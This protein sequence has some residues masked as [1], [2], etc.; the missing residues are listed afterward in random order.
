MAKYKRRIYCKFCDFFC[1]EPD[2]F[3]SHLEKHHD[4][5]IPEDMTPWQFSYYL[6]TNKT[7]GSCIVCKKDTSWN[8]K[9]HKYNRFCGNPACKEKYKELFKKRMIG[10]YG[11][12]TLLN[13]PEHQ[14]KMLANRKISG[15]Y[16]WR[17]HVHKTNYTGSY[18]KDFLIFLDQIMNFDPEDVMAPSPHTYYY[19]YEG[20]KH[21]YIPDFFIPSLGLEIEIKDG[22]DNPNMHHKIQDVDKVKEKLKDEVMMKNHYDYIKIV[23]KDNKKFFEYLDKAKDKFFDETKKTEHIVM[24]ED[25]NKLYVGSYITESVLVESDQKSNIDKNFKK[26]SNK[27]INSKALDIHS[28][29]AKKYIDNDSYLSSLKPKIKKF[30]GEIIVDQ[31]KEKIIGRFLI[32]T[33]KD[34]GF[35]GA[36]RVNDAYKGYGYGNQL[37]E[38]AINKYNGEDL[39]VYKDNEVARE[40][41]KKHG[42][43]D[44]NCNSINNKSEYYMKLKSKLTDS[45]NINEKSFTESVYDFDESDWNGEDTTELFFK[46]DWT[47]NPD[48]FSNYHLKK[49]AVSDDIFE[50]KHWDTLLTRPQVYFNKSLKLYHY[51]NSKK[52]TI[53]P[54]T[55]NAGNKLA[56]P[57]FSSWWTSQKSQSGWVLSYILF[58]KFKDCKWE[59]VL[60]D[61]EEFNTDG[62]KYK[63]PR[64]I[65]SQ[66]FFNKHKDFIKSVDIYE[67]EKTFK[68]KDLGRGCEYSV[69][70]FT[71]DFAVKPDKVRRVPFDELLNMIKI[72]PDEEMKIYKKKLNDMRLH[73]KNW[74]DIVHTKKPWLYWEFDV[75]NDIRVKYCKD[76]GIDFKVDE[77]YFRF[78]YQGIGI[79]EALREKVSPEVWKKLL[80]SSNFTWL[81][82]PQ[83]YS[84][85]CLSYFTKEGRELFTKKVLPI[86][87]KYL[88]EEIEF[89]KVKN[90]K[91]IVYK[92]KYQVI[93]DTDVKEKFDRKYSDS[94]RRKI[95]K[96]IKTLRESVDTTNSDNIVNNGNSTSRTMQAESDAKKKQ[97]ELNNT[98]YNGSNDK[99]NTQSQQL[100]SLEHDK[101]GANK[102]TI[103][104]INKAKML[105]I[106]NNMNDNKPVTE[107]ADIIDS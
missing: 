89:C 35:I 76:H 100:A 52:D 85:T 83:Y 78:T 1:Y 22:G 59:D 56:K 65:I 41:Y 20:K 12:T 46:E 37:I 8:E 50:E 99:T 72:V 98:K 18:E 4:E 34:K 84:K 44:V 5:M 95:S 54:I 15:T 51:S 62:L 38:D 64:T 87:E 67:H 61:V 92:D 71:C 33:G 75:G 9:T 94:E 47:D 107:D 29:E 63:A 36:V 14:K 40:I 11:K 53:I 13:D 96:G 45:D 58:S 19:M 17:D 60:W 105:T 6:R 23:N 28:K 97:I 43:V 90:L 30:N 26:K 48:D 21:F 42:F 91:N 25:L 106:K 79:Y 102:K 88:G 27:S 68:G 104:K 16:L 81:P 57:R 103:N 39:I 82:K 77:E 73:N 32:G 2:D 31:D 74:Q 66:S 86:C 93:T 7:H 49:E 24:L 69:D 70:E 10:K 101:D 3:V 55:V 80:S